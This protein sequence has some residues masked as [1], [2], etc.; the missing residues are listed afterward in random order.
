MVLTK[1]LRSSRFRVLRKTHD[2]SNPLYIL[3]CKCVILRRYVRSCMRGFALARVCVH[4][5]ILSSAW[6]LCKYAL[7]CICVR[8]CMKACTCGRT[9]QYLCPVRACVHVCACE[10]LH[11]RARLC[12]HAESSTC[13]QCMLCMRT[14]G[15]W[16][17]KSKGMFHAHPNKM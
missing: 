2:L 6:S 11:A 17:A 8:W 4:A 9:K 13:A 15:S 16:L 3:C 12:A 1:H 7:V 5:C 10:C 14:V